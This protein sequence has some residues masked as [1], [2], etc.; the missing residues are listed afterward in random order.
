[1]HTRCS[2]SIIFIYLHHR[3]DIA[4]RLDLITLLEFLKII[5]FLIQDLNDNMD[6]TARVD[7]HHANQL[8]HVNI[9]KLLQ[10]LMLCQ[11]MSKK[12]SGH[13]TW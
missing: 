8:Q 9:I 7:T 6:L 2:H 10:N 4:R 11:K 13:V 1:M 12:R 3:E 5:S